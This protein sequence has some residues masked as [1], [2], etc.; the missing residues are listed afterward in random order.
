MLRNVNST[1]LTEATE[2]VQLVA[3]SP[4]LRDQEKRKRAC[5]DG[6]A[7][8]EYSMD[9]EREDTFYTTTATVTQIEEESQ[10]AFS[11]SER[12]RLDFL[13]FGKVGEII[14]SFGRK[15][16]II[17][18]GLCGTNEVYNEQWKFQVL[19]KKQGQGVLI[20]W[21]ITN[22]TSGNKLTRMETLG[23]AYLRNKHGKTICNNVVKCACEQ[24]AKELEDSI[25]YNHGSFTSTAILRSRLKQLRPKRCLIGLLFFGLQ[26]KILQDY[27]RAQLLTSTKLAPNQC[28]PLRNRKMDHEIIAAPVKRYAREC[29]E[30]ITISLLKTQ[31]LFYAWEKFELNHPVGVDQIAT[32]ETLPFMQFRVTQD[33]ATCNPL[34]YSWA[35]LSQLRTLELELIED[36]SL[37]P[38]PR[39]LDHFRDVWK[40]F[41]DIVLVRVEQRLRALTS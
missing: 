16:G 7:G 14:Q 11:S 39:S 23:E 32:Q 13:D 41:T 20:E 1:P 30:D 21:N 10:T 6:R 38:T 31:I 26:H 40:I 19:H 15:G 34:A 37:P 2:A 17:S 35:Q 36:F 9:N 28:S 29:P 8:L 12:L 25:E 3:L 33:G 24:R 4:R 22:L 5:G 27:L 18:D